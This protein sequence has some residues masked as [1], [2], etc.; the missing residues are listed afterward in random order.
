M[1]LKT[2]KLILPIPSFGQF[3]V[4]QGAAFHVEGDIVALTDA[5]GHPGHA[6]FPTMQVA[7]DGHR[8]VGEVFVG[9]IIPACVPKFPFRG[10]V[11]ISRKIQGHGG[12][13]PDS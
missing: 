8:S 6:H 13:L 1:E 2:S 3:Q 9:E 7:V 12:V 10:E 11:E 4:L 5:E